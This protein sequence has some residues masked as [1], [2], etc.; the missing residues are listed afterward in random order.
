MRHATQRWEASSCSRPQ[1][2]AV[3]LQKV[4]TFDRRDANMTQRLDMFETRTQ[5]SGFTQA[6]AFFVPPVTGNFTFLC[7]ADDYGQLNGTLANGTALQLCSLPYW[8]S[9]RQ[10]DKH[11]SQVQMLLV[12]V[13]LQG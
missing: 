3:L 10:W 4:Y 6:R 2:F 1:Q 13:V 11:A 9:Y 7:S 12:C 8:S 5:L